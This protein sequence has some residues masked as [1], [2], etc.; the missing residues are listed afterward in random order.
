M[1]KLSYKYNNRLI[2]LIYFTFLILITSC[3]HKKI[4]QKEEQIIVSQTEITNNIDS[5]GNSIQVN[6]SLSKI[7]AQPNTVIL[8]GLAQHRLVTIYK[9]RFV[10]NNSKN[11]YRSSYDYYEEVSD[12]GGFYIPG[13]DILYGYNLLNIAHYDL[14]NEKLNFL[15]DKS[16]L[17]KTLYY[18][19]F[20]QDSIDNKPITR[21][22]YFVS[23]YDSDTNNDTLINNRDLRRFYYFNSSCE[24]KTQ[25]I[26]SDYSVSRAQYDS[27]ND[28]IYL[29]AYQDLD[30][31]GAIDKS[32]PMHIFW[33]KLNN[34]QI[35]K[36]LF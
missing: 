30:K 3:S 10:N 6:I 31:N 21:F 9:N 33:I 19:S 1:K 20:I 7:G 5:I 29:F 27:Q 25:L 14:L 24:I 34:P 16:V 36:R 4:E 18:P 26:P 12:N 22:N 28:I 13:F 15:F 11:N 23:V 35:A 8:T 2:T 32:E 17:I